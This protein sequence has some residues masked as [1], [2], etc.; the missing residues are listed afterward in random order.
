LLI[1]AEQWAAIASLPAGLP[2]KYILVYALEASSTLADAV[3][4]ISGVLGLP[5]VSIQVNVRTPNFPSKHVIRDAGP[6][7]FLGLISHAEFVITNS[8]HGC[9]FSVI[10][11]KQFFSPLHGTRN[12]RMRDF[13]YLAGLAQIQTLEKTLR[14]LPMPVDYAAV[15]L[16]LDGFIRQSNAYL[17]SSINRALVA[18]D[19]PEKS[20]TTDTV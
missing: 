13:F 10:F 18:K 2:D 17:D 5:V 3:A 8:F 12:E 1:P 11:R 14:S 15:D 20:A 6:R 7:E 9:I 4:K 16:A 19:Q